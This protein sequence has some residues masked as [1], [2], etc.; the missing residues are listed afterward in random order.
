[1][2]I[3]IRAQVL[4]MAI[5]DTVLVSLQIVLAQAYLIIIVKPKKGNFELNITNRTGQTIGQ[6]N[7][8][9]KFVYDANGVLQFI[10][11]PENVAGVS[12]PSNI[13]IFSCNFIKGLETRLDLKADK[14]T[15]K[16]FFTG[17]A[18]SGTSSSTGKIIKPDTNDNNTLKIFDSNGTDILLDDISDYRGATDT[19]LKYITNSGLAVQD[20]TNSGNALQYSTNSGNALW[21]S[22]NSGVA[23][24]YSTNSGSAVRYSKNSGYAL[25]EQYE[26]RTTLCRTVRTLVYALRY[27]TNSGTALK[28]ST[29]SVTALQSSTNSG[30][31]LQN[32][33]NS[34]TALRYST[35]SG[36]ALR[37]S[38]NS[39]TALQ[40]ST[41]SGNALQSSTNS[42]NALRSSKNSGRALENS[43]FTNWNL[44]KEITDPMR[45]YM[46][47]AKNMTF[48]N[49]IFTAQPVFLVQKLYPTGKCME[50]D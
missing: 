11:I 7:N 4:W 35:N 10:D 20:S 21:N 37:Y 38:T 17:D 43:S 48:I 36:Y 9:A 32:S 24:R 26:L 13:R 28:E 16:K 31:A 49:G 40:S 39:G 41:N 18:Y 3:P 19:A 34:G 2:V 30:N 27:S 25:R 23:L 14:S 46:T 6:L 44:N 5:I 45:F 15:T 42:G 1:M 50:I 47:S 8:A 22:K 33:T 29:N 12:V